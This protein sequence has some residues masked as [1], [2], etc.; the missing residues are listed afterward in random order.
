[1]AE[2]QRS[3]TTLTVQYEGPVATITLNRPEKRNA[4]SYELLDDLLD[5]LSDVETSQAQIL[6]LTGAGKAFSAG[7][8]LETLRSIAGLSREENQD[9]AMRQ[10]RLMRTLF[11]SLYDFSKVTIAAVN[12]PALAGGCGL[13]TLCDFTIASTSA[14][15]GYTE[16]RIGFIPALVSVFLLGKVGEKRGRD[17]LLSGRIIDPDEAFRI[18]LVNEVV[19]PEKLMPR[20]HELA[21]QLLQNCPMSLRATK[22]LLLRYCQDELD[23][24]LDI[25]VE[26]NARIR[27]TDD[28]REGIRSFLEKR[29][30]RWSGK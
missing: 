19:A 4:I 16:V 18:G 1:M 6:I 28:F 17:L 13:A 30:P 27:L 21:A 25:A 12:G 11:R 10:A 15:F 14:R 9:D 22:R 5:A 8:D 23:R 29:A 26:E 2:E 24:K 7:M 3:F 20:A